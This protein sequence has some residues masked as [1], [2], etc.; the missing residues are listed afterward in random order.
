M[1]D[2]STRL[3]A[4]LVGRYGI[5]REIGE[6]ETTATLHPPHVLPLS[7]RERPTNSSST[8]ATPATTRM[9]V[10]PSRTF[11]LS[12]RFPLTE[13][14]PPGGAHHVANSHPT[15]AVSIP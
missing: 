7:T 15:Q 10:G 11:L 12:E 5:E 1:S 3:N 8:P 6:G 13:V 9:M 14:N 2:P 4:A